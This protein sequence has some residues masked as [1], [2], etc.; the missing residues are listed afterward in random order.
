MNKT[1]KYVGYIMIAFV[2]IYLIMVAIAMA[3][4]AYDIQSMTSIE[5]LFACMPF[6]FGNR[7]FHAIFNAANACP[8][9]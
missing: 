1:A 7:L 9:R 5:M 4:F 2:F 3:F 6:I 8:H